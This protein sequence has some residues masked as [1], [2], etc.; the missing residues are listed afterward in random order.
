M[1]HQWRRHPPIRPQH[2]QTQELPSLLVP[3][4]VASQAGILQDG[5]GLYLASPCGA[6]A[7]AFWFHY[8]YRRWVR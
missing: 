1:I 3:I 8:S 5:P 6:L 2:V 4:L 7:A